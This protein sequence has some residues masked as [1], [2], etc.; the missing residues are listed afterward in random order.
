MKRS[1]ETRQ[2]MSESAKKRWA[3]IKERDSG[4]GLSLKS[5]TFLIP[6]L[7]FKLLKGV[8]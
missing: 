5:L 8:L 4:I 3:R 1:L 2:K 6:G 7:L